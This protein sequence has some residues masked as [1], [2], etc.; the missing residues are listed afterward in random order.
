MKNIRKENIFFLDDERLKFRKA[1]QPDQKQTV[2]DHEK[3]E[4]KAELDEKI[5]ESREKSERISITLRFYCLEFPLLFKWRLNGIRKQLKAININSSVYV[6]ENG[7]VPKIREDWADLKDEADIVIAVACKD[8]GWFRRLLN[9]KAKSPDAFG[10]VI[11]CV[12]KTV[13][14]QIMGELGKTMTRKDISLFYK[15]FAILDFPELL[16]GLFL[17]R[18]GDIRLGK[19]LG[20]EEC[21]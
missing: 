7:S 17:Q 13:N 1:K 16:N 19:L 9:I 20:G 12:D 6:A 11:I 2:T 10:H 14:T 15:K 21:Q 5:R 4:V 3:K 18:I 8:Y